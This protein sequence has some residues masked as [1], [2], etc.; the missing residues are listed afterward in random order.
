M[1][2]HVERSITGIPGLD[3]ILQG[4]LISHR[5]YLIDGD[6]G[7][8]K[9]T[10]ALQYLLEGARAGEKCLYITLSETKEELTAGAASH[11]WSLDGID[12]LE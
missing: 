4:G 7:A 8:G 11:G 5:L 3:D 6:P 12:I 10:L 2:P 1:N 9:T